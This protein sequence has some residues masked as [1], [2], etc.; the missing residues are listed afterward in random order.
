MFGRALRSSTSLALRSNALRTQTARPTANAFLARY[1]SQEHRSMIETAVKE[2]PLVIFMKGTPDV[3]QCG[4]SR[5]VV[6]ILGLHD[7]PADKLRTFNVLEDQ[8]LRSAIKEYS[9]WPTIPQVYVDGE[10]VGGCDIVM[11]MHQS[12]ELESLLQK[13]DII[14]KSASS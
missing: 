11:G 12:G 10:F 6:Q 2:K 14:P 4:F 3:P 1:L 13:H 8:E 7:V 9:D 5:A